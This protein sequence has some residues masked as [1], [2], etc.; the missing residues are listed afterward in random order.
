MNSVIFSGLSYGSLVGAIIMAIV[1]ILAL[2]NK[3][4]TSNNFTKFLGFVATFILIGYALTT[5]QGR[6]FVLGLGLGAGTAKAFSKL[7]SFVWN[8]SWM[9]RIAFVIVTLAI[10]FG[11]QW[12]YQNLPNQGKTE[13]QRFIGNISL[14]NLEA[15]ELPNGFS[16][17]FGS[18]VSWSSTIS[19]SNPTIETQDETERNT[20]TSLTCTIV[21]S[22]DGVSI[23][24]RSSPTIPENPRENVFNSLLSGTHVQ[25]LDVSEDGQWIQVQFEQLVGWVHISVIHTTNCQ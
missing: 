3:M 12:G 6:Y 13:I 4:P 15:F 7:V 8:G 5:D 24:F 11:G 10:F 2:F 19:S 21:E 16:F 20:E 14:R 1:I 9:N 17:D 18:I 23:N 22:D 25:I